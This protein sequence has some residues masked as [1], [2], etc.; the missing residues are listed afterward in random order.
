MKV[1][2]MK[3]K[4]QMRRP[5]APSAVVIDAV[6]WK[7]WWY[8]T[9]SCCHLPSYRHEDMYVC[10]SYRY[11]LQT[12]QPVYFPSKKE[13]VLRDRSPKSFFR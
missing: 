12:D 7:N 1:F 5:S 2:V 6:I 11:K 9:G 8:A 13:P 3:G 10:T 4:K